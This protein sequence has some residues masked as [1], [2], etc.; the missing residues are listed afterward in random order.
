MFNRFVIYDV[1]SED[2]TRD[3]LEQYVEAEKKECDII[4]RPLPF[5]DPIV[6]GTFRNAMI[7]EAKSDWYLI[8][9]ADEIY[10]RQAMIELINYMHIMQQAYDD[11]G[12]IYGIVKRWEVSHDLKQIHGL[13]EFVKHH[14]IY[15]RTAIWRGTH[16]GEVPETPQKEH[17]EIFFPQSI[18]CY[19]FH[20]PDRSTLDDQVPKRLSRRYQRTYVRGEPK[21]VDI[22]DHIPLLKKPLGKF[23][24]N[25]ALKELQDALS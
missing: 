20:Q 19:H 3:I 25:P 21:E 17:R 2:A 23:A 11:E 15:H 13:D 9:D 24:V 12:R 14:R 6:Q 1:G 10:R 7:A 22:F 5:C 8:L 18:G 4:Y 16:P